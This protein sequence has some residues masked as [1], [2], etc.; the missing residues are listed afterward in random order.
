MCDHLSQFAVR[1]PAPGTAVLVPKP[2]RCYYAHTAKE[3]PTTQWQPLRAHLAAVARG[4]QE[5]AEAAVTGNK[6]LSSAARAAGLLHDLGKY[7]PQFQEYLAGLLAKGDPST[8][9]KQAGAAKACAL[10]LAP[11]AFAI[12]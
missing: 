5:R 10:G 2:P 1:R 6:P 4:A 12:F 9:H 3:R 11:I 7:R 8:W